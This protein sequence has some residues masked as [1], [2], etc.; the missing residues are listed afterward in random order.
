MVHSQQ[1]P[2]ILILHSPSNWSVLP[3]N[4]E[5][6][7]V[8][9]V[10]RSGYIPWYLPV[11]KLPNEIQA[12]DMLQK[13][14]LEKLISVIKNQRVAALW[15]VGGKVTMYHTIMLHYAIL[16]GSSITGLTGPDEPTSRILDWF[17]RSC[18]RM[19]IKHDIERL[20]QVLPF[21]V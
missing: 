3:R 12:L 19:H 16:H 5:I 9:D 15:L 14:L 20:G 18:R 13:L 7:I 4:I 17:D 10:K 1:R 11:Y 6:E 2:Y 21:G 8:A